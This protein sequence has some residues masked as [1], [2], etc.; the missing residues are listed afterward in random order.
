MHKQSSSCVSR[1]N[2]TI[3]YIVVLHSADMDFVDS[4]GNSNNGGILARTCNISMKANTV[5]SCKLQGRPIN[6]APL[7][8]RGIDA[9]G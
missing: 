4:A 8:F 1:R 9:S 5:H 3:S 6:T 2:V 7:T